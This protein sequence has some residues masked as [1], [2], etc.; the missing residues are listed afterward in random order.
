VTLEEGTTRLSH[1][2]GNYQTTLRNIPEE[3]YL[4]YTMAETSNHACME[5]STPFTA[6]TSLV[7]SKLNPVHIIITSWFSSI[8]FNATVDTS[9][10][11]TVCS[12]DYKASNGWMSNESEVMWKK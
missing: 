9:F 6:F 11:G 1:Y 4:I 12:P 8:Y 3:E 2:V 10:N 5:Y 7:P